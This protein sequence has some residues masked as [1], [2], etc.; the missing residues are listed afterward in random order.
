MYIITI[1][2]SLFQMDGSGLAGNAWIDAFLDKMVGVE[3]MFYNIAWWIWGIFAAITI[4]IVIA[5]FVFK[6]SILELGFVSGCLAVVLLLWPL[7]EW[8]SVF[9]I[10]GLANNFSAAGIT[11]L[12]PFILYLLLYLSIGAG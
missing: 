4:I 8:I 3:T 11:N 9:L 1:I 2:I 6:A 5:K 10:R 7:A 12:G